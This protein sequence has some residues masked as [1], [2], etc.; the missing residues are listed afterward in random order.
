MQLGGRC[1][2]C[3]VTK[4]ALTA[5]HQRASFCASLIG[6]CHVFESVWQHIVGAQCACSTL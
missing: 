5:Q 1:V 2:G 6:D 4:T 3:A